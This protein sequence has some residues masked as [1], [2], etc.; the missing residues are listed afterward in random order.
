[1]F[2][3][4]IN[5]IADFFNLKELCILLKIVV[6]YIGELHI[7]WVSSPLNN[8]WVFKYAILNFWVF[9]IGL[10]GLNYDRGLLIPVLDNL[11]YTYYYFHV[12]I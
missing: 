8:N 2:V 5:A 1:M 12:S 10:V 9:I 3:F 6:K 4:D 11:G 7:K